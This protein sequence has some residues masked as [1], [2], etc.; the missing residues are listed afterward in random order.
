MPP[1]DDDNDP[2]AGLLAVPRKRA[3]RAL[4]VGKTKGHKLIKD[5]VLEVLDLGPRSKPITVESINRLRRN[6]N[7][8]ASKAR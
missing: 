7:R 2:F 8:S 6:G 4:S 5:G 1:V 3:F